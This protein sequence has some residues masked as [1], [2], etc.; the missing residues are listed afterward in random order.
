MAICGPGPWK[1]SEWM[2]A[3]WFFTLATFTFLC[4]K[5]ETPQPGVIVLPSLLG[6][7][8]FVCIHLELLKTNTP[9]RGAVTASIL[10][11]LILCA[12]LHSMTLG[13]HYLNAKGLP[14]KYLRD[15][16]KALWGLLGMRALWDA[17]RVFAYRSS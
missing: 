8:A 11:S 16:N 7:L 14:I 12:A 15:A 3:G 9:E 1:E 5:K 4:W 2:L 17:R 6:L 10:A 13:H